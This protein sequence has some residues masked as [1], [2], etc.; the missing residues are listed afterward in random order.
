VADEEVFFRFVPML[1]DEEV[2]PGKLKCISLISLSGSFAYRIPKWAFSAACSEIF[3]M[4]DE[5]RS[6]ATGNFINFGFR[7]PGGLKIF[8]TTENNS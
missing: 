6:F 4:S 7:I 2:L 3:K 1:V 5:P 8:P